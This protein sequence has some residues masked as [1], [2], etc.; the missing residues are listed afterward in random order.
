[1]LNTHIYVQP[2]AIRKFEVAAITPY[3]LIS[4]KILLR[5]SCRSRP[6]RSMS[7]LLR[8]ASRQTKRPRRWKPPGPLVGYSR[9]AGLFPN[10]ERPTGSTPV[11]STRACQ[12]RQGCAKFSY[13]E[14]TIPSLSSTERLVYSRPWVSTGLKEIPSGGSSWNEMPSFSSAARIAARLFA[15]GMRPPRSKSFTV[16][17]ETRDAPARSV[18][19]QAS[20]P[21][22]ARHCSGV[23]P[24][25]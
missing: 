19:D 17:I 23:I 10:Q 5:E 20:H 13:Q 2:T 16:D 14:R 7:R 15:I 8:R 4:E 11:V 22:A 21:R 18:C 24:K 1:M 25:G 3:L 6:A 12:E 9:F